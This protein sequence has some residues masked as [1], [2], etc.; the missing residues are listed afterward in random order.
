MITQ[1][2]PVNNVRAKDLAPVIDIFLKGENIA[3][4]KVYPFDGANILA[5]TASA[6]QHKEL[7]AFFPSGILPAV[8][9]REGSILTVSRLF[10]PALAVPLVFLTGTFWG[11]A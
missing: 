1:T 5:V 9:L 10:Y 2:Y 8:R 6:S 4:T 7:A 11:L 3:G